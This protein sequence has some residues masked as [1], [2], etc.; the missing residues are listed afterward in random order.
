MTTTT[1]APERSRAPVVQKLGYR[2]DLDGIRG[3]AVL[4]VMIVHSAQFIPAT[5]WAR[6]H[7]G[8]FG[9]EMFFGLSGFLI[10]TLLLE[11]RTSTG[12]VSFT[13]FYARRALRLFPALMFGV[14]VGGVSAW[15][16]GSNLRGMAFPQAALYVF[17]CIAN[18]SEQSLGVF[19]H[20]WTLSVEEQYYLIWPL[21]LVAAMRSGMNRRRLVGWLA[22]GAALIAVIRVLV[23]HVHEPGNA[24]WGA[25]RTDSVMIGSAL[26]LISSLDDE[27][28]KR[29]LADRRVGWV[30]GGVLAAFLVYAEIS[31]RTGRPGYGKDLLIVGT[32]AFAILMGRMV[33]HAP[34]G[35]LTW[36]PFVRVGRLSYS[37]Y[38]VHYGIFIVFARA[39]LG[40][41]LVRVAAAWTI[42]F[43]LAL[44]S[45]HL[46]ELPALR[47]KKR[48]AGR[49][50]KPH[51]PEEQSSDWD[52]AAATELFDRE[53]VGR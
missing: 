24:I 25:L 6:L 40:H 44:F 20:L 49:G 34:S 47:L 32:V 37:V 39:S 43:A 19:G 28:I 27:R 50:T 35:P 33:L 41:P 7:S 4:M 23:I 15:I 21:V 13:Q 2:P 48:L 16:L 1:L 3:V 51:A 18:W 53:R 8:Y 22:G 17:T 26:A 36:G 38:L 12:R 31:S 14:T 11:E 9:V 42:S 45:Y 5:K 29:F 46:I 52:R 10:T 30:S